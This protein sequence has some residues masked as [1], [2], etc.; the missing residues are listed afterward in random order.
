MLHDN[1]AK[2]NNTSKD[3]A[4]TFVKIVFW[5]S[6]VLFVGTLG[7]VVYEGSNWVNSFQ[8]AAFILTTTGMVC[9]TKTYSGKIYSSI[10]NLITAIFVIL[11][12]SRLFASAVDNDIVGN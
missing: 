7:F 8:N 5:L 3:K 4:W 12:I 6:L 11:I 1:P 10:Y 2:T 9:P